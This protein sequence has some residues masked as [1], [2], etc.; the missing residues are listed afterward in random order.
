MLEVGINLQGWEYL[1]VLLISKNEELLTIPTALLFTVRS[2]G[3][4]AS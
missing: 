4:S 2:P 3:L 1:Q